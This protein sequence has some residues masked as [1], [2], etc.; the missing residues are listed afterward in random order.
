[1]VVIKIK[2]HGSWSEGD[3]ICQYCPCEITTKMGPE[4]YNP[5]IGVP[6]Y[7]SFHYLITRLIQG[8]DHKK[9]ES[10]E[11]PEVRDEKA[12]VCLM[13]GKEDVVGECCS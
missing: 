3:G 5:W 8:K 10:Q 7:D 13:F 2:G 11:S 9:Q 1:M 6:C 4:V 12:Q